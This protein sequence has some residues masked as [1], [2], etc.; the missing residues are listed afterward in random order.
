MGFLSGGVLLLSERT[1]D[2]R[3]MGYVGWTS[4]RKG[5]P[6]SL[7]RQFSG[8]K[9]KEGTVILL[10]LVAVD[11][12]AS[13]RRLHGGCGKRKEEG[14]GLLEEGLFLGLS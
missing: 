5:S 8:K 9:K 14:I 10:G 2:Q 12:A 1:M 3:S 11:G 13:F 7:E 4:E 6:S